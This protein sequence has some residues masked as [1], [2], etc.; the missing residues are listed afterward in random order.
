M[1]INQQYIE[2]MNLLRSVG[3]RPSLQRLALAKLLFGGSNRHVTAEILYN[4]AQEM[5]INISLA[6]VY[7]NLHLFT[8]KGVLQEIFVDTCC[9]FFDTNTSN[10]HHIFI[11]DTR[12]LMD[13]GIDEIQFDEIPTLPAGTEISGFDV[14][15]RVKN[16]NNSV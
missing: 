16:I 7:N 8:Q 9:S 14:I 6:T 12:E 15:I 5:G 4:E 2:P 11:E 1:E 13:I 10:H 3:L